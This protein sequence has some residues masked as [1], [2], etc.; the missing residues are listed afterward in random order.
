MVLIRG[1]REGNK[2][3]IATKGTLENKFF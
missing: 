2:N 1:I 3:K